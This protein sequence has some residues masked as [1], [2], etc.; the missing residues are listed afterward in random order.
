[1]TSQAMGNPD[2]PLYNPTTQQTAIWYLNDNVLVHHAA[3]PTL[4]DRSTLIA[5]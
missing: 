2:F 1:M 3:G 4:P 5:P